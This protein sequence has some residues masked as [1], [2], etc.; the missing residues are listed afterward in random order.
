MDFAK[1]HIMKGEGDKSYC[2]I[3]YWD[4]DGVQ[5]NDHVDMDTLRENLVLICSKCLS[6]HLKIVGKGEVDDG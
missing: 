6:A 5:Y 2:G 3:P 1:T 4:L